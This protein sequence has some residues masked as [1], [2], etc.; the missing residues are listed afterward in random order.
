MCRIKIFNNILIYSIQ[1]EVDFIK[2]KNVKLFHF[3]EYLVDLPQH[4]LKRYTF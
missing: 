3:L 4:L 2:Y 1:I